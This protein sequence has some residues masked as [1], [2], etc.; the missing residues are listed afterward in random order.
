MR[1]TILTLGLTCNKVGNF[2]PIERETVIETIKLIMDVEGIPAYTLVD[3][4]G[5]WEGKP[6]KSLQII[7]IN[8]SFPVQNVCNW[9]KS[10]LLQDC[11]AVEISY[12]EFSLL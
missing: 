4:T 9:L 8:D 6:E 10:N 3:C 2:A 1:K 5:Y 12:P 7:V 11:I